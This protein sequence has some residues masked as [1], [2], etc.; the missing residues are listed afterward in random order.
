MGDSVKDCRV[1]RFIEKSKKLN[2]KLRDMRDAASTLEEK[3]LV[4][5]EVRKALAMYETM[6]EELDM[7]TLYSAN[8]SRINQPVDFPWGKK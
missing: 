7:D 2:S 4:E 6:L 5:D 8:V 1:S 3:R